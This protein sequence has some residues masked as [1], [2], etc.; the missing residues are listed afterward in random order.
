MHAGVLIG[1]DPIETMTE[2]PRLMSTQ[3]PDNATLPFF[4]SGSVI[5]GE[6]E[7]QE[8]YYVSSHLG[9]D[10][11]MWD[12]EGKEGDEYVVKKLLSRTGSTSSRTASARS[13]G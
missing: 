2:V 8:A 6:D 12:F 4:A 3:H 11:G 5:E 7:I 10:E 9:C 1:A 13:S